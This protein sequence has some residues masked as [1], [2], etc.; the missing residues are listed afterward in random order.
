MTERDVRTR[1]V[2]AADRLFYGRGI[3]R[4]GMDAVRDEAGA[5]LK[6]ICREFPSKE[7]GALR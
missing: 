2:E 6:A 1:I 3:G 4:V 7:G 5:S